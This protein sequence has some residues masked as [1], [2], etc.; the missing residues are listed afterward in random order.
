MLKVEKPEG[1]DDMRSYSPKS[2]DGSVN[3]GLFHRGS[4]SIAVDLKSDEGRFC[5]GAHCHLH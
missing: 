3:F 5:L 4:R 1:S 2:G